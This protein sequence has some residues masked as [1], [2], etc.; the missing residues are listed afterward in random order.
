MTSF[1]NE[2]EE[3]EKEAPTEDIIAADSLQVMFHSV[4]IT[5]IYSHAFSAKNS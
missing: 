4:E 3:T 2:T 1:S 5:E